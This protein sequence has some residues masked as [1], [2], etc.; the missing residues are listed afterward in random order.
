M[1]I[2]YVFPMITNNL[3]A[4]WLFCVQSVRSWSL[5]CMQSQRLRRSRAA[6]I[7]V[8]TNPVCLYICCTESTLTLG[9]QTRPYAVLRWAADDL[10][11]ASP[12]PRPCYKN[13]VCSTVVCCEWVPL[14]SLGKLIAGSNGRK[15]LTRNTDA[16]STIWRTNVQVHGPGQIVRAALRYVINPSSSRA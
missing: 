10:V 11:R 13:A 14:G 5:P 12:P 9:R 8:C 7:P 15:K 1:R 2:R 6:E 16:S 4:S 3:S